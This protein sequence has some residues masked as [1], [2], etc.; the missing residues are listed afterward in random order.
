MAA[1]AAKRGR[2]GAVADPDWA[3]DEAPAPE[4]HLPR[5]RGQRQQLAARKGKGH[6]A[7]PT[8]KQR[9]QRLMKPAPKRVSRLHYGMPHS[10]TWIGIRGMGWD[11]SA[12]AGR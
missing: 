6:R 8:P 10:P 7:P 2:T 12:T 3:P 1:P 11:S 9:V 5:P 4:P